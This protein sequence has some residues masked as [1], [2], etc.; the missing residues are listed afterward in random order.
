MTDKNLIGVRTYNI[1]NKL[2]IPQ[3]TIL[4][5]INSYISVLKEEIMHGKEV[6]IFGLSSIVPSKEYTGYISTTA[7]H[8]KMVARDTTF[9]YYTCLNVIKLYIQ[10]I[11][12]DLYNGIN[13]DVRGIVSLAVVDNENAPDSI[14]S[15]ISV[16]IKDGLEKR[17]VT[18][19][20]VRAHTSMCLKYKIKSGSAKLVS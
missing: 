12:D 16:T 5:I 2:G 13:A 9:S 10:S 15:N 19:F 1:S 18:D 6:R 11:K 7:Y 17:G 3:T 8:A 14:Y 4:T 20:T